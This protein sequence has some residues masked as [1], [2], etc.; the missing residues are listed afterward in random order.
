SF[1][2]DHL[3]LNGAVVDLIHNEQNY[4]LE[5]ILRIV[6][7][8]SCTSFNVAV[9][10]KELAMEWV[11]KIREAAQK[12]CALE[13]QNKEMERISRVAKEMSNLIIYCSSISFNLERAKQNPVFYEMSSFSE[14][15]AEKLICQQE[16]KFFLKY[17]QTQFSRIYPKGQRIDSSNYNPIQLWNVGSQMVA[18]NYQTGDK[19]MQLNQA[20]FKD[21]GNCGYILKPDFMLRDDFDPF[22]VNTLVGVEPV[23]VSIRIIA[24]RHLNRSKRGMASPFVEVEVIGAEFDFGIK[25]KTKTLSDNGFNPRWN[26]ICEFD[27]LNPHFALLRFAVH[28]E[29]MFGEANLIGQATYPVRLYFFWDKCN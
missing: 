14:S 21:N 22:D 15:K 9:Q 17:H 24:A 13:S 26:D 25:L 11:E 18:L 10:T 27:V 16:T 29:D 12:A 8:T 7:S 3:D 28:D 5:W 1:L 4:G 20:K 19:P 2:Q 6:T 23:T